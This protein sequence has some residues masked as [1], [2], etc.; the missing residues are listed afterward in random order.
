MALASW[1]TVGRM[2]LDVHSGEDREIGR[3]GKG[4]KERKNLHVLSITW[5]WKS[6]LEA[7][8]NICLFNR[9]ERIPKRNKLP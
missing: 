2:V 7:S 1:G 3:N 8:R 6:I 9:F 4:K 5:R